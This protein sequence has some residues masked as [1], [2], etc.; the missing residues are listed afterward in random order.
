MHCADSAAASCLSVC[1]TTA[2]CQNGWKCGWN[3]PAN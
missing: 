3:S 1:H 2:Q